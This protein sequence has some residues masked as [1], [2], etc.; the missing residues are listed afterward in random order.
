M[1]CSAS[2]RICS[3]SSTRVIC[4]RLTVFT[5]TEWPETAAATF[6]E[7]VLAF[8][9]ASRIA[10]TIAP[11]LRK[12][13]WTIAS[14]GTGATPRWVSSKPPRP[15]GES[16]TSFTDEDPMS[17]PIRPLDPKRG[18]ESFMRPLLRSRGPG[19]VHAGLPVGCGSIRAEDPVLVGD[20]EVEGEEDLALGVEPA[21]PPGFDA[22]DRERRETGL[23]RELRLAEQQRLAKALH[24][25]PRHPLL[26]RRLTTARPGYDL[27]EYRRPFRAT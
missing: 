15:F 2:Q 23:A 25:V 24:V 26:P 19:G 11:E 1:Y 6:F 16:S 9:T 13:P 10:S 17:R 8:E 22:V 14:F 7:R 27:R 21:G 4:G 20:R 3:S 12:A 18:N 5:I